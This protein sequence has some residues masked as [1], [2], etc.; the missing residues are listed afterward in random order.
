MVEKEKEKEKDNKVMQDYNKFLD[1]Q[2]RKRA[3]EWAARESRIQN[4]MNKMADTVVRKNNDAERE[5]ERRVLSYQLEKE[6]RDK[7]KEER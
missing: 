6:E 7:M 4:L 3:D 1:D 5:E 2:D